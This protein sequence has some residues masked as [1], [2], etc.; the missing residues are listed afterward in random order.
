MAEHGRFFLPMTVAAEGGRRRVHRV[1]CKECGTT[2]DIS[3]NTF[4]GSRANEDLLNVWRR[5]GWDIGN[6]PHKDVCP[7]CASAARKM[8]RRARQASDNE[9]IT[10]PTAE[11]IP[12]PQ[13]IAPETTAAEAPTEPSREDKRVI[14]TKLNEVYQDETTGYTAGWT[15]KKVAEDLGVPLAWVASIREDNFGPERS[16]EEI[17]AA[18]AEVREWR[19]KVEGVQDAANAIEAEIATVRG[20]ID[21]LNKTLAG[22]ED[23]R[24]RLVQTVGSLNGE[25][26][27]LDKKVAAI[28]RALLP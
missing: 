9:T 21:G 23:R 22:L 10:Q 28:E 8:K 4:S 24:A 17:K 5:R 3:A 20:A 16:N 25:A 19:G 26:H 2:D 12:M 15:D 27:R 7:A 11:I 18:L 13:P 14:F 6:R 1:T